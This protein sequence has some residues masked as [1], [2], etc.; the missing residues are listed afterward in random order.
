[1]AAAGTYLFTVSASIGSGAF[2]ALG[3]RP[4]GVAA[5]G[6][7]SAS[8][9]ISVLVAA[10]GAVTPVDV[11]LAPVPGAEAFDA[12]APLTLS[13]LARSLDAPSLTAP[14][15]TPAFTKLYDAAYEWTVSGE[16]GRER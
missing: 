10:A 13:C 12:A 11:S 8:T 3:S 9:T 15:A 14:S 4:T 16:E 7:R 5:P 2:S 1:M 6:T